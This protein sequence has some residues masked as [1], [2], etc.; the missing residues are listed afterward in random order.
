M[1]QYSSLQTSLDARGVF[2]ISLDREGASAN[3]M[4]ERFAK[5]LVQCVDELSATEAKGVV[6]TSAK[7]TFFAGGDLDGLYKTTH[8][9]AERL[10]E[11]CELIKQSLRR[12]ETLGVPVIA[13]IEGSALGGGWEL[14]LACHYR[15]MRQAKGVVVGLPEVTL[16]LLPGGGGVARTV[17]MFG[18]QSALPLL[19]EGRKYDAEQ[20]L[21]LNLIHEALPAGVDLYARALELIEANPKV[22]QPWDEKGYRLPGGAPSSPK[23]APMLAVAPAMLHQKTKGVFPA[24]KAILCAMVEGALVDFDTA[25]RIESRYFVELVCGQVSKNMINTF[26]T[27]SMRPRQGQDDRSVF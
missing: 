24:P 9:H 19:T 15:L 4:D 11:M 3:L 13:C 10:F 8:E 2:H 22:S 16:G 21:K 14:A 27:S 5:D 23:V 18:L 7:S 26:G 17:R 12:M 25:C 20:A 1:T 6:I